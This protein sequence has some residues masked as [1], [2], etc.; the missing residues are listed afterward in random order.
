MVKLN[1]ADD[2]V[3]LAPSLGQSDDERVRPPLAKTAA[4][5]VPLPPLLGSLMEAHLSSFHGLTIDFQITTIGLESLL[6]I[7]PRAS[8]AGNAHPVVPSASWGARSIR[9]PLAACVCVAH[10]RSATSLHEYQEA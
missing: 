1:L 2:T 9:A 3:G 10:T 6:C 8:S 4:A 5:C 7:W